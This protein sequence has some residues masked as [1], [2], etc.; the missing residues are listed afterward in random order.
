[1]R[2]LIMGTFEVDGHKETGIFIETTKEEVREN[3]DL[4]AENVVLKLE[5]EEKENE[6][7]KRGVKV[8]KD[9]SSEIAVQREC[10]RL[11]EGE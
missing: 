3:I 5:E 6:R 2:V 4:Y 10:D 9:Y 11:L 7:L 1:M 8:I